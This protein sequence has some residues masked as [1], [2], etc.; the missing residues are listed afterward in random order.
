MGVNDKLYHGL[1]V[2]ERNCNG[3]CKKMASSSYYELG[4]SAGRCPSGKGIYDVQECQDAIESLGINL[5]VYGNS[6]R[7]QDYNQYQNPT[8]KPGGVGKNFRDKSF[9]DGGVGKHWKERELPGCSR[10]TTGTDYRY[11]HWWA[12]P[13]NH[14]DADFYGTPT[15]WPGYE[16]DRRPTQLHRDGMMYLCSSIQ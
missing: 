13:H 5:K 8:D 6:M 1:P 15:C 14:S 16:R 12:V 3:L 4:F 9:T 10:K 7:P 2:G 11:L